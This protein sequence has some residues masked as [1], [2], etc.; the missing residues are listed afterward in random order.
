MKYIYT[1]NMN[2]QVYESLTS[3]PC[4]RLI[5]TC[6]IR[7]QPTIN[8]YILHKHNKLHTTV[9]SSAQTRNLQ[10]PGLLFGIVVMVVTFYKLLFRLSLFYC[11]VLLRCVL[12]RRC[13][14][15]FGSRDTKVNLYLYSSLNIYYMKVLKYKKS[16]SVTKPLV[17]EISLAEVHL[18]LSLTI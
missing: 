6:N 9:V 2:V 15:A 8:Q 10:S 11:S 18:S 13:S 7:R 5:N 16:Q 14:P 3:P 17:S 4:L 12:F 1:Y